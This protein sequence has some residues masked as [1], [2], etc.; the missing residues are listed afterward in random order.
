MKNPNNLNA[1]STIQLSL[2]PFEAK[3]IKA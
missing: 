3:D 2:G 1:V